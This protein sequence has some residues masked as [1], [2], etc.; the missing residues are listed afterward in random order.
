MTKLSTA[1][2]SAL[3][4]YARVSTA[5]QSLAGQEKALAHCSRVFSDTASG[6]GAARP[7]LI[8]ALAYLRPGDTLVVW[9][10]DRLGRNVRTLIDLAA[11][12]NRRK[13]HLRS[14]SEGL[15]TSTA[16]GRFS[17][18]M[19]ASLA[20]MERE[21]I[22]ERT[23][24]G[25][26]AAREKGGRPPTLNDRQ[27]NH[28]AVLFAAGATALEV[29]AALGVSRSTVFRHIPA[30]VRRTDKGRPKE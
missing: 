13:I 4:G 29:A 17:F 9:R 15:D 20:Q 3:I 22:G 19:L 16:A 11:E 23:K 28:A 25:L 18:H 14:L 7:G 26:A 12:L 24:A 30:A 2:K 21:L 5:D 10:L 8:A 1:P 27:K 6:R